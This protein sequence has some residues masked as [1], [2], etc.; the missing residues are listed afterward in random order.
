[1]AQ[2][3]RPSAWGQR[4]TRSPTW[5]VLLDGEDIELHVGGKRYRAPIGSSPPLVIRQGVFWS[6]LTLNSVKVDGLP[7]ALARSL[8]EALGEAITRQERR[9]RRE[10]FNGAYDAVKHW[11]LKIE[12]TRLQAEAGRRWITHEQQEQLLSL[13]PTLAFQDEALLTLFQDPDV[14][15]GLTESVEKVEA[16]L[17][18][19]QVN[20]P[21]IWV[22]WNE[23]HIRRE[24]VASKALLDRVESK[25]LT[26]E[27]ARAVLCFDNRVQVVAS[28]G[29]GKTSTMVAK[30][31]YAI[32]RRF[33]APEEVVL[34]A[35]NKQ[36]AEELKERAGCAFKRLDMTDVSVE[37]ST[38]HALGLS[39]IGKATGRKPR[40]PDWAVDTVGGL[41]KLEQ[42]INQLKDD[43]VQFS[44]QWDLF[45]MVFGRDI[46]AWGEST[47][48]DGWDKGGNGYVQTTDGTRVK[49]QEEGMIVNWLFY[50]GVKYEY[51]K[52]YE[53]DTASPTHGQY[54]PDFYYPD[55]KLYHEHFAL[56][57]RGE[58]PPHFAGYVEGVA[59]KRDLHGKKGTDLIETTSHQLRQGRLFDHLASELS[60]RGVV[61]DP[62]PDRPIPSNGLK[63]LQSEEFISLIRTFISHVKSNCL[64]IE[65]LLQKLDNLPK[66]SFKVRHELFLT[67]VDPIL[68]A[69]DEALVEEDGIDFE[70]MLN[71]AAEHLEQGR[72]ELPYRLVMADEFQD[73]SRARARLCRALVQKPGHH[74]FAVGDDWQSI[75]RFAGADVSVMTGFK[76]W[77]GHGQ[78][79]K[80]EQTFRCPQELCDVS[81]RFVSKNPAQISKKVRSVTLPIGPV[82]QAFEVDQRDKLQGAIVQFLDDL[83]QGLRDGSVPSGRGRKTTVFILGRYNAELAYMPPRWSAR[84]GKWIDLAFLTVH[85]SKGSEADYVILPSMISISKGRSFPDTRADDSVL[86]LAMPTGDEFPQSEER[87][88]FYV[89]V[90]RARRSVAIFTVKGK[91][92]TFLRELVDEQALVVTDT[93]GEAIENTPCPACQQGAIVTK[94]G[95][96]GIF[97]SCSNFPICE[98]KPEKRG[99]R[100]EALRPSNNLGNAIP[101]VFSRTRHRPTAV[102]F[103]GETSRREVPAYSLAPKTPHPNSSAREIKS[104]SPRLTLKSILATAYYKS[105]EV[106]KGINDTV[107]MRTATSD[108]ERA[109]DHERVIIEKAQEEA[110]SALRVHAFVAQSPE[111][112]SSY[113][114]SYAR[115]AALLDEPSE[116]TSWPKRQLEPVSRPNFQRTERHPDPKVEFLIRTKIF[117]L[118]DERNAYFQK[119]YKSVSNDVQFYSAFK[120]ALHDLGGGHC[121]PLIKQYATSQSESE[122]R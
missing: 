22:R 56:N 2:E 58:A 13:R 79:L 117:R 48:A 43:S 59:W 45:R 42:I 80:L 85:R 69:W 111:H 54:H 105:E 109:I 103:V 36:A 12:T 11:L 61:L 46:P 104:A 15:S 98:Y 33:V 112:A 52:S 81:S 38:F 88:L 71:L 20:W 47:Q 67:L 26:E 60:G 62:N 76:D 100:S 1:M 14:K 66:A 57:A 121:W 70:D 8:Q 32:H 55:I 28:A 34:L 7:N 114:K 23:D 30:A 3:W 91:W 82:L 53:F 122:L 96:Y 89:A 83:C 37:A 10:A 49:S 9:K 25:P 108:L 97:E 118:Q 64:T 21:P 113:A 95:K 6:D 92:S 73:A 24:L 40:V 101:S 50:N 77:F 31:A 110:R 41:R 116:G 17:K 78:V 119:V 18:A 35:F 86:T 90:T 19:W 94:S 120:A 29:S 16:D 68:N 102:S 63:P 99:R 75:N 87:R 72:C 107:A 84:Y 39:I 4:I 74:L 93:E 5:C 106:C 65:S 44:Q 27:Q 51:E 115:L